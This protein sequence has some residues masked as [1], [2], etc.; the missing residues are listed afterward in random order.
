MT[1]ETFDQYRSLAMRTDD[2]T[3]TPEQRLHNAALGLIGELGEVCDLFKKY[4]YHGHTLDSDK[5]AK[6]LGDLCWYLAV[7]A[8]VLGIAKYVIDVDGFTIN[9]KRPLSHLHESTSAI[10]GRL[11]RGD[12]CEIS[13]QD[14]ESALQDIDAIAMRFCEIDKRLD[15]LYT[16]SDVWANNIEKLQRRYPDGFSHE[17]S[18]NRVV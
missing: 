14:I 2:L 9:E 10:T 17:A 12:E 5:L 16:L 8:D 7:V 4:L 18:I 1:I 13:A 15:T 6:E 11:M 3:R